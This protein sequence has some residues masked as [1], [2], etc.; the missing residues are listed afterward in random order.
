MEELNLST[1]GPAQKRKAR[2]RRSVSPTTYSFVITAIAITPVPSLAGR[3]RT[4][5]ASNRPVTSCVIVVPFFGTWKRFF[6]ASSTAFEI[7][8]G[9]S[10]ALP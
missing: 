5:A 7:A 10:R 9:T 4:L 8:S 3:R 2:K 6:F 1:L